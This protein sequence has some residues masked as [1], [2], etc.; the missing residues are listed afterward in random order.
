MEFGIFLRRH[1]LHL[2]CSEE[3]AEDEDGCTD[4]ECIF[5]SVR[6]LSFRSRISYSEPCE[7]E[8]EKIS[9]EASCV[10]EEAL[11]RICLSLLL[12]VH[13][14]TDKHLERLH[15]NIDRCVEEHERD[16]SED[17]GSAY[18]KAEVSCI[19]E[20]AHHSDGDDRAEEEIRDTAA[21]TC[22]C[23]VAVFSY[24]R[25]D[26]ESHER[27]K[28]PEEAEIM[29][30]RS[31]SRKDAADIGVLKGICNLNSEESEAD[32]PHLPECKFR[33]L[34]FIAFLVINS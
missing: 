33:F 5:H 14:V 16:E 4:V 28:D 24:E 26:D 25:L 34:H 3:D 11:D 2:E 17:H 23:P 8:W 27:R 29:R 15:R 9:H 13:H 19:R 6:N 32:I 21:Q 22:P 1:L 20:H 10:A 30:I 31:E 7:D 12:F 18:R